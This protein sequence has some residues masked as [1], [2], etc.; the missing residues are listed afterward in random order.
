MDTY[1]NNFVGRWK[2]A[3]GNELIISAVDD[4]QCSVTF[5]SAETREPLI[6]PWLADAPAI[7]MTA[8]YYPEHSPCLD[9]ELGEEGSGF[10]LSLD[11]DFT[12]TE[13]RE[14]QPAIDRIATDNYLDQYYHCLGKLE[15]FHRVDNNIC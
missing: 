8:K 3:S 13:Y 11:F 15:K 6:R 5:I 4:Y 1:I 12:S 14:I 2:D 10:C 9:I 7:D